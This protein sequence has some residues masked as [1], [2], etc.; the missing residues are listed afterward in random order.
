[1]A[2]KKKIWF[3]ISL[4]QAAERL[5]CDRSRLVKMLDYFAGQGWIE[6]QVSGLVHGYRKLQPINDPRKNHRAVV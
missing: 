5:Q 6:L 1:M 3:E 4:V 2:V